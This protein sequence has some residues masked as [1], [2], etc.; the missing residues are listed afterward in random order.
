MTTT[1]R[2]GHRRERIRR[3]MVAGR[4]C[5]RGA[6]RARRRSVETAGRAAPTGVVRTRSIC[7]IAAASMPLMRRV[8]A[9]APAALRLD[10]DAG[11][12]PA[13]RSTT[14]GGCESSL[15]LVEAFSRT[16]DSVW[17]WPGTVAEYDWSAGRVL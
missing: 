2:A 10:R 3:A 14:R 13:R 15:Q 9:D 11:R 6:R 8:R 16:A 17:S 1:P 5:A 12:L 7:T 4:R